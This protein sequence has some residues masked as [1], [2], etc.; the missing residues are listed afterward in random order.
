MAK[1]ANKML[2][3]LF[4]AASALGALQATPAQA[5][6]YVAPGEVT[7]P[8]WDK[9]GVQRE[10]YVVLRESPT[11][12][13][14]FGDGTRNTVVTDQENGSSMIYP[15]STTKIMTAYLLLE[16]V[17]DGT[18]TLNSQITGTKQ[19]VEGRQIGIRP[20]QKITVNQALEAM[21]IHSSNDVA[22]SVAESVAEVLTGKRDMQI[23]VE[24]MNL[25]AAEFNMYGT[26][27]TNP[28]GLDD[29]KH[30]STPGDMAYLAYRFATDNPKLFDGKN[31]KGEI[32]DYTSGMGFV[33][34]GQSHFNTNTLVNIKGQ[35]HTPNGVPFQIDGLKTG[36]L[37]F[38]GRCL[39]ATAKMNDPET[40]E[41]R[42]VFVAYFGGKDNWVRHAKV[43][44]L[45]S[46]AVDDIH[47]GK[48]SSSEK[49][50]FITN[51]ENA[52]PPQVTP[53]SVSQYLQKV[54]QPFL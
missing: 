4:S 40:G 7:T 54:L 49:I 27:F 34:D 38:A 32:P 23:F 21:L 39:L 45:L 14:F 16:L 44:R 35:L 41:E 3:Y 28:A 43:L 51:S 24:M 50:Q 33:W 30:V 9:D 1:L 19:Y 2:S 48:L 15:A 18:L 29:P 10:A 11:I 13:A 37:E 36:F 5:M 31:G 25:K 17:K 53:S 26:T 52:A 42:R 22:Y 47:E 20:G 8:N 12:N 46:S 6:G